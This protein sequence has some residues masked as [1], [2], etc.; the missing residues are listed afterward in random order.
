MFFAQDVLFGSTIESAG[1]RA[2]GRQDRGS[3]R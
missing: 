3:K 2:K 1:A